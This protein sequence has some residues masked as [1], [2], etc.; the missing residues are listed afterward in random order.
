[1][2]RLLKVAEME[3]GGCRCLFGVMGRRK[4]RGEGIVERVVSCR[5]RSDGFMGNI[6]R[7]IR[8]T[9]E[10]RFLVC[11][12]HVS[13]PRIGACIARIFNLA[14]VFLSIRKV[15]LLYI[16]EKYSYLR[17]PEYRRF[18]FFFLVTTKSLTS[19]IIIS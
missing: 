6:R 19:L 12:E 13:Y 9:S 8:C 4:S 3:M 2:S 18:F 14:S 11:E 15:A 5:F 7:I 17:V 16:R 1:M 10:K